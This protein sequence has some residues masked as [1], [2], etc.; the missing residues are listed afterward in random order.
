MLTEI[1]GNLTI[2][3]RQLLAKVLLIQMRFP[4]L[5]YALVKDLSL[6]ATLTDTLALPLHEREKI[7]NNSPEHVKAFFADTDLRS[8]LEKTR[9]I[10][11]EAERIGPYVMLIK[12]QTTVGTGGLSGT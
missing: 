6:V 3:Q 4:A 8:F 10:P 7:I 2:E 9:A 5:Y 12:G 11:C 1:A